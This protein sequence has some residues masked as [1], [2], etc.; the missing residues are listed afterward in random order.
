MLHLLAQMAQLPAFFRTA[1]LKNALPALPLRM[2]FE[3]IN[4]EKMLYG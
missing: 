1:V 4:K 3:K 2:D